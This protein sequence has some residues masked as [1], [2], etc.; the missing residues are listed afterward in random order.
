MI[1]IKGIILNEGQVFSYSLS[2]FPEI[3]TDTCSIDKILLPNSDDKFVASVID[4]KH[5]SIKPLVYGTSQG[6]VILYLKYQNI[7][8]PEQYI[9]R[10]FEIIFKFQ[11][12]R[13]A[14]IIKNNGS[15]SASV[16]IIHNANA[17]ALSY[18][19][20]ITD[21][22]PTDDEY[23]SINNGSSN[24]YTYIYSIPS[25]KSMYI[26]SAS[27]GAWGGSSGAN[28]IQ[29]LSTDT[30]LQGDISAL[31]NESTT[32]PTCCFSYLFYNSKFNS[33]P[34]DLL[35][36]FSTLSQSCYS[37]MF[38]GCTNLVEM[39]SLPS[40]N[41]ASGCYYQMFKDCTSLVNAEVLPAST[42]PDYAYREMFKGCTSLKSYSTTTGWVYYRGDIDDVWSNNLLY[43]S[44]IPEGETLSSIGSEGNSDYVPEGYLGTFY[45]VNY[46]DGS[47]VSCTYKFE[48]N[49]FIIDSVF[50]D[51]EE[52]ITSEETYT[53]SEGQSKTFGDFG[54]ISCYH[55]TE[56]DCPALET[57]GTTYGLNFQAGS[58]RYN[59]TSYK[60]TASSFGQYACSGMFEGCTSFNGSTD[61]STVQSLGIYCFYGMFKGCTSLTSVV[62]PYWNSNT[63]ISDAS[64]A[65]KEMYMNSGITS[66]YFPKVHG[67]TGMFESICN[68]CTSLTSASIITGKSSAVSLSGN[69][70]FKY[71]F[72]G[73][74]A[75]KSLTYLYNTVPS[76]T[77]MD[78]WVYNVSAS[79]TFTKSKYATWSNPS[80][81]A[82]TIPTNFTITTSTYQ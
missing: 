61:F 66:I 19:Y 38:C 49:Q 48:N 41:L 53:L 55:N 16:K 50:R 14:L 24:S 3:N 29:V 58:F 62:F 70:I 10:T 23:Q 35:S 5:F 78:D 6:N 46:L 47:N 69:G 21:V 11:K 34:K 59:Y 74:T 36:K 51:W 12:P 8:N 26:Y 39:P 76:A 54:I 4:S 64:Y 33:V 73:C 37:D 17:P 44:K 45:G 82:D 60:F 43:I 20:C 28:V 1:T 40:E 65:F 2:E 13:K 22:E 56:F 9:Y 18:S 25:G 75:L 68:G 72:S 79:G 81:G 27:S 67:S 42:V 80:K 71:A 31:I 77:Y 15:S 7:K 30:E 57:T 52:N 63:V 32:L